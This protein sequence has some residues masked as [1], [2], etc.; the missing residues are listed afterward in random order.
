MPRGCEV[1]SLIVGDLHPDKSTAGFSRFD[2]VARALELVF[3]R[4]LKRRV[5]EVLFLGDLADPESE[6]LVRCITLFAEFASKLDVEGIDT[7]AIPG[8]HDVLEDGYGT[9]TLDPLAFVAGVTLVKRPRYVQVGAGEA[10]VLLPYVPTSHAYD[11]KAEVCELAA[12]LTR[13]GLGAKVAAVAGHLML[14]GIAT[15]SETKDMAR[16]RDVFFPIDTVRRLFPNALLFNA[17]Y[18]RRQTY[19]GVEIPGSVCRFTRD[20]CENVPGILEVDTE[21]GG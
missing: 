20:E 1:K 18:H 6:N 14:E 4:A 2:D 5:D 12:E 10:V 3:E 8:N 17:H 15:G 16:G 13:V 21:R 9:T 11:P 19:R 7:I